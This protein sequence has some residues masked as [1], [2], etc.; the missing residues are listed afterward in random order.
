MTVELN[1]QEP[2]PQD[3]LRM[4][5]AYVGRI[6][7][8]SNIDN[9]ILIFADLGRDLVSADR[10]T[11]WIVDQKNKTM[12]SKVAH[13]L[14]RIS[15]PFGVGIAGLTAQSGNSIIINDAYSDSRFDKSTDVRTGY[16]T[17]NIIAQPIKNSDG[18]VIGVFQ[19]INKM[20]VTRNF[21]QND[22]NHLLLASTYTGKQLEAAILKEE[23]ET[24]QKEIIFTL[25]ETGEMRSK[26]TGNHVKRVAEY[27]R[28][29]A[30]KFGLS[31]NE[32]DLLKL[33]SP[34]H[35][36]GKIAIPDAVLLKPGPFTPEER[37]VM[38]THAALGYEMLKHSDRRILKAASVVAYEHHERWDGKGY[39]RGTGGS[40]I[41][42]YGQ[43]T[44]VAD[45]FDAL[46]SDRCYKKAWPIEKVMALLKE[47]RGKQFQNA[48]ID[49]FL[50]NFDSFLTIQKT[51]Q[52]VF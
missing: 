4:I 11:V 12:W 50:D 43:I 41:H 27:S 24:T 40:D 31:E 15:I 18:I 29:L 2:T 19:A 17:R 52:D 33:A 35:D 21:D 30:V 13:G 39:P 36:I 48:M 14:D 25:A 6:A 23:I 5:F 49:A 10:C 34:L 16:H 28:L 3:L 1:R 51:Y 7:A 47:E 8:E 37:T 26:E 42:I 9:L 46:A 44:A 22:I 38:Q 45:V 32:A 20:T